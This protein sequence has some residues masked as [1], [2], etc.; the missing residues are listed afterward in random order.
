MSPQTTAKLRAYEA[1][2]AAQ[3]DAATKAEAEALELRKRASAQELTI[4]ALTQAR[5]LKEQ[6]DKTSLE[7][8]NLKKTAAEQAETIEA[9]MAEIR[10]LRTRSP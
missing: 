9:L 4:E 10:S 3:A 8:E 6:L 1:E 7:R 2:L 5:D